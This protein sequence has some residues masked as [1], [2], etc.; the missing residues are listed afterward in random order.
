MSNNILLLYPHSFPETETFS[1]WFDS[2]ADLHPFDVLKPRLFKKKLD[3]PLPTLPDNLDKYAY[4]FL[5]YRSERRGKNDGVYQKIVDHI[6]RHITHHNFFI[7]EI[8]AKKESSINSNLQLHSPKWIFYSMTNQEIL[9]DIST[10][11]AFMQFFEEF[12]KK[13]EYC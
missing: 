11:I 3:S 7:T 6:A 12:I 2:Y 8:T 13:D 10:K 9:D 4:I 1:S 5:V